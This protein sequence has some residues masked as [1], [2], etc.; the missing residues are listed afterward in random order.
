MKKPR[1]PLLRLFLLQVSLLAFLLPVKAQ[2]EAA[3]WLI[4]NTYDY[5]ITH[6]GPVAQAFSPSLTNT[7]VNTVC[8]ANGNLLL[9]TGSYNGNPAVFN[10]NREPL[11][12]F[13]S[14]GNQLFY[15]STNLMLIQKPGSATQ[16]YLFYL[17]IDGALTNI[18][19]AIIDLAM[20]GG[21][22]DVIVSGVLVE[23]TNAYNYQL[24][25]ADDGFWILS[26]R[27]NTQIFD[28]WKVT[29][30]GIS[31]TPVTSTAGVHYKPEDY[32]FSQLKVSPDGSMVAGVSFYD[33]TVYTTIHEYLYILEVFNFNNSTGTLSS[34]VISQNSNSSGNI[35]NVVINAGI[36][37][38][39]FSPDNRFL[40]ME[41]QTSQALQP[42][43]QAFGIIY[44]YN[45][46]YTNPADFV[47]YRCRLGSV[48]GYC[49]NHLY[50]I[51]Q[52]APDK[53]IYMPVTASGNMAGFLYPNRAGT[54]ATYRQSMTGMAGAGNTNMPLF[55]HGYINNAVINNIH[56]AGGC[57][58]APQQFSVTNDTIQSIDWNFGDAASGSNNTATS[59]T[60]SHL[61]SA[62]GIYLVTAT[63]YNH[64]GVNFETVTEQ[65]EI[66]D[67][68][69]KLLM[70]LPGDT[71]FCSGGTIRT[72]SSVINGIFH[73]Q[74]RR[75]DGI[76][77]EMGITDSIDI[78]YYG[79]GT[80]LVEMR[81][82]DCNGCIMKDSIHVTVLPQPSFSF[83]DTTTFCDTDSL[84]LYTV[85]DADV[86]WSTG[87]TTPGITIHTTGTYWA[88]AE[89]DHNGCIVSATTYVTTRPGIRFQFPDDTTL[90]S[91]QTLLL[92][93]GITQAT[94]IWQNYTTASS[95]TV[96]APGQYWLYLIGSNGCTAH[97]TINVSYV[98]AAHVFLGNDTTLCTGAILPLS[99]NITGATE[100]WSTGEQTAAV[101]VSTPGTYWVRADNGSCTVTDTIQVTYAA[102]PVFDLG[103]DTVLCAGTTLPLHI[104]AD[105]SS[106][107]W[108]DGSAGNSYLISAAGR[109]LLTVTLHGCS[110][111]DS[112][113]VSYKPL[114]ALQLP[115]DTTLCEN[116]SLVL[117]AGSPDAV[118][119]QWQSGATTSTFTVNT[120]GSYWVTIKGSNNCYNS[121]TTHISYQPLPVFSLGNDTT[122]CN[123]R[124]LLLHIP[125]TAATYLWQDGSV[126][127]NYTV[128]TA[129]MY[130]ATVTLNGCS[131]TDAVQVAYK[132]SPSLWLGNDTTVCEGVQLLLHAVYP[133][134]TVLWQDGKNTTD[135]T[136]QQ[137]GLYSATIDLNGCT[138][139]DSIQIYYRLKPVFTLGPDSVICPGAPYTLQPVVNE[140]PVS[141]LWQDGSSLPYLLIQ[142]PGTYNVTIS[143]N[144][145]S[146]YDA[147]RFDTG[148]CNLFIPTAFTP[149]GDGRNDVFRITYSG[150]L[151]QFHLMV[152]NRWGQKMFE[153]TDI[154]TGWDGTQ[155]GAALPIGSYI[156]MLQLTTAQGAAIQQNGTVTIIR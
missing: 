6:S 139:S 47:T 25:K 93:P 71:T 89:Y 152:Y 155:N 22:G 15:Q 81:Q 72:G 40:Y 16:F 149:N 131:Q 134:T 125:L 140:S 37:Y 132:P 156:W 128:S 90:C 151:L 118:S 109:Y 108:Q 14:T 127:S 87:A 147:I 133:G 54:S 20:D 49:D 3:E 92:S 10:K 57:Y 52:V 33:T 21:N 138:A 154:H 11:P 7:L 137:P 56:Y 13:R 60:P 45:L 1:H 119:Y 83:N 19:C 61:F 53:K 48:G 73:Y 91:G 96:T 135:Y 4:Q 88:T 124:Q 12:F 148:I 36:D 80:Y 27:K 38:L 51:M 100:T 112:I 2:L 78:G 34:R 26:H 30:A 66:K 68:H 122:L 31:S 111:T 104:T 74:Y 76:L 69:Q 59:L 41:E 9:A 146:S 136:V 123:G 70:N 64:A 35:T 82:N 144:C 67:P 84:T 106:F 121:D 141:Y 145:G 50:G 120:A 17:A 63:L 98:D 43:G 95:F 8:D 86:L 77:Y 44:Q 97:D 79:T 62:P 116:S 46:C 55:Y 113:N 142:Q 143:N 99:V 126:N 65:I 105:G 101:V 85:Y 150:V 58:P 110:A 115:A 24:L 103:A 107:V 117:N 28:A 23:N 29:A 32:N 18:R 130:T 114:P 102:P 94:Y 129:G 5:H 153:T 42:C 75:P 39:E